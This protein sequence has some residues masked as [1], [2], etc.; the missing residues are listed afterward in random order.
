M[1]SKSEN[2]DVNHCAHVARITKIRKHPNADRLQIAMV[3]GHPCIVGLDAKEGD[4]GILLCEGSQVSES[5]GLKWNL[6]RKHPETGE[7]LDGYLESNRRIRSLK[8]R[9]VESQA[10][11][12][13][14]S[15]FAGE[16]GELKS[17]EVS[18]FDSVDG[19]V[20]V[21]KY[22]GKTRGHGGG[23]IEP[24]SKKIKYDLF[25]EHNSTSK[26]RMSYVSVWEQLKSDPDERV[27]VT[28][29]LHGTSGRTGRIPIPVPLSKPR[30]LW[31]WAAPKR[32]NFKQKVK[33]CA[34]SGT[35][36]CIVQKNAQGEKGLRYRISIHDFLSNVL[37]DGETL[38]YEIVGF[39][40][41][42][43][44]I[45][46]THNTQ[47][48]R[49]VLGKKQAKE[50]ESWLG[51]VFHY[52]YGCS[53]SGYTTQDAKF[54]S[55][56]DRPAYKIIP[57]RMTRIDEEGKICELSFSEIQSLVSQI[58]LP[59]FFWTP[60]VLFDGPASEFLELFSGH[61][62]MLDYFDEMTRG[63][64]LMHSGTLREG[65]CLRVERS[66][67]F[68]LVVPPALKHKGFLFCALEG[69]R[70]NDPNFVDPEDEA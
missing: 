6:L 53:N 24:T 23:G 58:D 63:P 65:V 60:P 45:M 51:E 62:G 37:G 3:C 42:G 1:L 69:I 16:L 57:Y 27:I 29:K 21:K 19:N 17:P 8:L 43:G 46:P 33:L 30:K 66:D 64:S 49:G 26:L 36:R 13:P 15:D 52:S 22:R 38:Y 2:F 20:V 14:E 67:D 35:R 61:E 44:S 47:G 12:L 48:L 59:N 54:A 40:E 28:E 68:G 18:K 50:V 4:I 56:D 55:S 32:W 7:L 9:G 10:L 25:P 11:F 34:V 41:R 5:F 39:N 31:N 70:A